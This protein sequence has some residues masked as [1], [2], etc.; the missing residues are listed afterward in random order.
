VNGDGD[1]DLIVA[2]A[3]APGSLLV[4]NNNNGDGTFATPTTYLLAGNTSSFRGIDLDGDGDKDVLAGETSQVRV[5]VRG[6]V[7]DRV[8]SHTRH[9]KRGLMRN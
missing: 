9:S 7:L 4:Y 1:Q 3:S 2:D 6:S 5:L 8:C